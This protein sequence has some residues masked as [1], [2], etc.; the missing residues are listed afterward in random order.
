MI[1]LWV[2]LGVTAVLLTAVL[3]IS[4]ICFR[5]A[6]LA[7]PRNPDP[8]AI[9]LPEG[10]IYEA[11]REPMTRWILETRAMEH[12]LVEITSFDGLTLRGKFFPRQPQDPIE[13]MFHGYRGSSERDMPGGVQRAFKAGHAALVVDQRAS[14]RSDGKVISFGINEHKDCLAWARFAAEKF[15]PDRKLILTGISMGAATVMM[16]AD[17]ALPANVVGILADCGY[18]SPKAIIREVIGTMG[19]PVDLA[20]PFVKLGARLYGHFDL[21]EESPENAL[22]GAKVPVIFFHGESDGYVPCHMS[23]TNYDACVAKKQLVTMPGA[24]HGLAYP[25]DPTRYLAE[26]YTFF[27]L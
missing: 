11:Y 3:I 21:E 1:Y 8:N 20:Y 19:L 26:I 16:T 24:D 10:E 5:M 17:K 23:Q 12:E 27:G 6:F 22:R 7:Q 4:Y 14:G 9:E 25:A 13:I 18:S 15:G 2:A